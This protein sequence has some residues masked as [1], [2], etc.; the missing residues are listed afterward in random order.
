MH[1]VLVEVTAVEL[2]GVSIVLF[3]D[4]CICVF[5]FSDVIINMISAFLCHLL[6][7]GRQSQSEVGELHGEARRREGANEIN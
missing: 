3:R 1:S 7:Y 6:G 2:E 4:A 5:T